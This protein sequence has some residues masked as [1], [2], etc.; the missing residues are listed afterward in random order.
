MPYY[1][2]RGIDLSGAIRRGKLFAKNPAELDRILFKQEI[3]L[4][5][6]SAIAVRSWQ[7]I[8]ITNKI[9]L[10]R[11]LRELLAAGVLLPDALMVVAA[12]PQHAPL[13]QVLEG[14]FQHINEGGNLA[15]ALPKYPKIF[16]PVVVH[17]V[18]AGQEAGQLAHS[19]QA[20][21]VYL[22][23]VQE[24]RKKL[25]TALLMPLCTLAFF[26][27]ITLIILVAII[28]RYVSMFQ[29]ANQDLPF[30]T[31][32]L[33]ACS[34]WAIH[35]G[36]LVAVGGSVLALIGLWWYRASSYGRLFFD[37][38]VLM[39]P[40]FGKLIKQTMA[41]H[42][43]HALSLLISNGVP[44]VAALTIVGETI[45]NVVVKKAVV[46]MAAEVQGGASLSAVLMNDSLSLIGDDVIT[47]VRIGEESA[48]L[49]PLLAQAA[50]A[51]QERVR[52]SLNFIATVAQPLLMIIL[53]LLITCLVFAVYWP[54]F[55]LSQ[56]F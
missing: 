39:I 17:M 14:L 27:F 24:F 20:L 12:Q 4:L 31:K 7:P 37:R 33:V 53:G 35:Y 43:F 40:Y 6:H 49:G 55:N 29:N 11:H 15:C 36:L 56:S 3:A 47:M 10:F 2:W 23:M 5:S 22:E 16:D 48:S 13:Q 44:L 25:S 8:T 50:H 30:V 38:M 18:S 19:L 21:I 41:A 42:L 1:A 34:N 32:A 28:P 46:D 9:D 52:R 51:Y 45:G 54:I 26:A